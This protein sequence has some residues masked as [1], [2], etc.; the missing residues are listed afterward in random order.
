MASLDPKNIGFSATNESAKRSIVYTVSGE[1]IYRVS[2]IKLILSFTSQDSPKDV[3]EYFTKLSEIVL[4]R[5]GIDVPKD[6]PE[7]IESTRY[8][9]WLQKTGHVSLDPGKPPHTE[10]VLAVRHPEIR[11]V[12]I[13]RAVT[14]RSPN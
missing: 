2:R 6:L 1:N 9:R 4:T 14:T 11:V 13:P 3:L 10:R 12:P 7:V 5:L 8:R